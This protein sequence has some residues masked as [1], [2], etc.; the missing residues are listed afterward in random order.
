MEQPQESQT[1]PSAP[2]EPELTPEQQRISQYLQEGRLDEART[3]LLEMILAEEPTL[4]L[5]HERMVQSR[6]LLARIQALLGEPRKAEEAIGP[7]QQVP[8]GDAQRAGIFLNARVLVSTLRRNQ[9]LYEEAFGLSGAVLEQ[10]DEVGG[11]VN[12]DSFRTIL[13]MVQIALEAGQH[14]QALDLC[15]KGIERFQ[16]K[17]G[18]AH[19]HLVLLAGSVFLAAEQ[20]D[21]AREHFEVILKQAVEQVGEEN[22]LVVRA[23]RYLG[24]LE[25][26]LDNEE[27]AKEHFEKCVAIL[28]K[29]ADPELIVEVETQRLPLMVQDLEAKEAINA[30]GGFAEL[31]ARVHGPRSPKVA[32][33]LASMGYQHRRAGEGVKAKEI[34]SA[35][36]GIW[37]SW[38]SAEDP[39]VK[40]LEGILAE[41]G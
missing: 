5:F 36:L 14:Q 40:L 31:V 28:S 24:Q 7:L 4:G 12:P 18:E 21:Q 26:D 25:A 33:V 10:L 38:R 41:L 8:E 11:P 3:A 37:R 27:K 2:V 20:Y 34:Y 39:K 16:E 30:L 29:G 22:E 1:N 6:F 15:A 35:A 13:Q 19:A 9:G 17:V 23:H 32:E